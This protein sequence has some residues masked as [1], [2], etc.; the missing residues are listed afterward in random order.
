VPSLANQKQGV[1]HLAML[2]ER[3]LGL[4]LFDGGAIRR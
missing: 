1:I 3:V 2:A 4:A